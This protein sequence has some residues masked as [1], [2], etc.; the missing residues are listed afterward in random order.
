[1]CYSSNVK[2]KFLKNCF[3]PQEVCRPDKWGWY[4][5]QWEE[6]F[7]TAGEEADPLKEHECINLTGLTYKVDYEIVEYP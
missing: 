5:D 6:A 3:A 7:F 1:M 4:V 2:I